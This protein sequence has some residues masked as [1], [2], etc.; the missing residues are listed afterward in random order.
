VTKL[1]KRGRDSKKA[2]TPEEKF[3]IASTCRLFCQLPNGRE[4][5]SGYFELGTPMSSDNE[6][7]DFGQPSAISPIQS[8]ST[9][10]GIFMPF[11]L[12][13]FLD[14]FQPA[15]SS[16]ITPIDIMSPSQLPN[17]LVVR[18]A[19]FCLERLAKHFKFTVAYSDF[20]KAAEEYFS[21]VTIGLDKPILCHGCGASEEQA[22]SDAA[23]NA[24]NHLTGIDEP[25]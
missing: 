8:V 9:L 15:S 3:Q 22:H 11:S 21:L 1:K 18:D 25:K 4:L 20:P 16:S 5:R 19:K 23:Y 2:L 17:D 10:N 7:L 14:D 13:R 6:Y 12:T 24:I